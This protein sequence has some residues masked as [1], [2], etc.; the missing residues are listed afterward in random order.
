MDYDRINEV[1]IL[2]G[3]IDY[4]VQESRTEVVLTESIRTTRRRSSSPIV[5][6]YDF[7][8]GELAKKGRGLNESLYD[9]SNIT[10]VLGT[11]TNIGEYVSVNIDSNY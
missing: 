9:T 3:T 8:D 5:L 10:V 4:F 2:F 6:L 1:E 11:I 7:Q